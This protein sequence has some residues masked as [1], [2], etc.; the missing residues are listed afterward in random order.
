[1]THGTLNA[2]RAKKI[3]WVM[4]KRP[5]YRLTPHF[6]HLRAK[7]INAR[8]MILSYNYEI[9]S[10]SI[11]YR[12]L[13]QLL[14][15]QKFSRKLPYCC[16]CFYNE[17]RI[18]FKRFTSARNIRGIVHTYVGM[19]LGRIYTN[20]GWEFHQ[21]RIYQIIQAPPT[22]TTCDFVGN[23]LKHSVVWKKCVKLIA[24]VRVIIASN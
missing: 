13:S 18:Y 9:T 14:L 5:R 22:R 20:I 24:T 7:M 2:S 6:S 8:L 3:S 1:M 4:Y 16:C 23:Y 12:N 19:R 10:L 21:G 17:S 15:R 11:H